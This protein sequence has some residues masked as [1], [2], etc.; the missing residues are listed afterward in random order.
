[1]PHPKGLSVALLGLTALVAAVALAGNAA[2]QDDPTLQVTGIDTD[3]AEISADEDAVVLVA[4]IT[5]N[6]SGTA[7]QGAYT[8][9]FNVSTGEEETN[10]ATVSQSAPQTDFIDSDQ[11]TIESSD[12]DEGEGTWDPSAGL[13]TLEVVVVAHDADPPRH[14]NETELPL[15]PDLTLID[16]VTVDP[17]DPIE[18]E[19]VDLGVTVLNNGTWATPAGTDIDVEVTVAGET[20]TGT[21]SGA[22]DSAEQEALTLGPWTAEPGTHEIVGTVDPDGNVNESRTSNNSVTLGEVEVDEAFPNLVVDALATEPIFPSDDTPIGVQATVANDGNAETPATGLELRVNGLVR[23]ESQLDPI[24][25]GASTS[26]TWEIEAD[27]GV[28]TL[29]AAVDPDDGV[30]ESA[31]DDN[32]RTIDLVVGPL[33]DVEGIEIQPEEPSDGDEVTVTATVTNAG[34]RVEDDVPVELAVDGEAVSEIV[35][36]GIA[37]N[38]DQTVELGPWTASGGTHTLTVTVDPGDAIPEADGE[39]SNAVLDVDVDEGGPEID[40][41]ELALSTQQ[42]DPGDEVTFEATVANDGPVEAD[43]VTVTFEVD[44]STVG[45]PVD[46]GA[47][48][49]GEATTVTS[50]TWTAEAGAHT[51]SAVGTPPTG[52]D[53]TSGEATLEFAI[54]PNLVPVEVS[55][56]PSALQLGAT[57]TVTTTIENRGTV[58]ASAFEAALSVDDDTVDEASVENLSARDTVEV[59]HLWTVEEDADTLTVSVDTRGDVD[60]VDEEDNELARELDIDTEVPDLVAG[61]V[62]TD[63]EAPAPGDNVTFLA[64]VS[65]QGPVQASAFTVA[66]SVD[67]EPLGNA[68]V[69]A[70]APDAST[71]VESPA[72]TA[73][74]SASE[75]VVDVD[76][77]GR[78]AESTTDNNRATLTVTPEEGS[79]VPAP[80]LLA[81][82]ATVGLAAVARRFH[83]W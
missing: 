60:E 23:E 58:N 5:D 61:T 42:I 48:A 30:D 8:V 7:Y 69:P 62:T 52:S 51:L 6:S 83:A 49:P 53:G 57:V 44:G 24:S 45:D 40:V 68:T 64:N 15:G 26:E 82:L 80:G 76:P 77:D 22:L 9:H 34:A 38:T 43:P 56:E 25:P 73:N 12:A 55:L 54:G 4:T 75:L 19:E 50:D 63:P 27:R 78:V 46:A 47:L 2:A 59:E 1:M 10:V 32:N 35:L 16:G 21:T 13:H 67:G 79:G 70:L 41:A 29:E 39:D 36:E 18:G 81:V 66:F 31:E 11:T 74:S 72:W 3:P 20:F 17:A 71:V 65:N 28:H 14:P 33:L 37:Q